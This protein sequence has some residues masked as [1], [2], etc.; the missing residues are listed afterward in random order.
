ME[1]ARVLIVDDDENIRALFSRAL[2]NEGYD[3][4]TAEG[5]EEALSLIRSY[6]PAAI[7]LDL[8]MPYINGAGFLFRLREDPAT[9]HIPVAIITGVP[10]V[11]DS[12]REELRA[13]GARVWFKPL[14]VEEIVAVART[15]L[16]ESGTAP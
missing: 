3:V 2:K 8:K 7:L 6:P 12:V 15:L 4:G 16:S 1:P 5:A 9:R 14:T 13:L 10:D 11:S